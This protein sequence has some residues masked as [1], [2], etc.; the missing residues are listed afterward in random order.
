I[1]GVRMA[2]SRAPQRHA[3]VVQHG[4]AQQHFVASV[5]VDVEALGEM[6]ALPPDRAAVGLVVVVPEFFQSPVAQLV[7]LDQHAVVGAAQGQQAGRLAVQVRHG[8]LVA[9][10]VVV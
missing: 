1:E 10:G 9:A 6:G 8:D 3:V 2:P 7:R 5:A 4:T